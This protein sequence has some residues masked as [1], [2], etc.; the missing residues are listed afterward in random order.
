MDY[1]LRQAK[2]NINNVQQKYFIHVTYRTE[3]LL[4]LIQSNQAANSE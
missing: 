2:I 3:Q 4:S 1:K